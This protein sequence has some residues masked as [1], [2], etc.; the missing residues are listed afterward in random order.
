MLG[1]IAAY[2]YGKS[3]A[4]RA[5]TRPVDPDYSV[6]ETGVVLGMVFMLVSWP[7]C[8]GYWLYRSTRNWWLALL[9][10]IM[11]GTV[12][13]ALPILWLVGA[14]VCVA[15]W[16]THLQAADEARTRAAAVEEALA[17]E[18]ALEQRRRELGDGRN[19]GN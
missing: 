11:L 1:L 9:L 13:L 2:A 10:P 19:G 8:A 7:V 18:R 5:A 17:F 3:R 15:V 12:A 14:G 16:M 4:R 6:W